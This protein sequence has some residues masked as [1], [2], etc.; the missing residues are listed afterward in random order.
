MVLE[1]VNKSYGD[2][3]IFRDFSY[4]FERGKITAVLGNS[5]VGKTTLLNI[6]AGTTS[7][8]GDIKDRGEVSFVF[9]NDRLIPNL[10]V[11]ENLKLVNNNIDVN[12]ELNK[13]GLANSRGMFPN[14]LSAGMARRVAIVRA[15]N[16]KSDVLLLDEAFRNLDYALKY[17]M[18]DLIK[19]HHKKNK[20]TIIEV[21]HDISEAVY[22]ADRIVILQ[23]GQIVHEINNI[24][25]NTEKEILK[26][27]LKQ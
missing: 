20:N 11:A 25:D 24:N 9:Q 21:T 19:T 12:E 17:K 8:D 3:V 5:G 26:F 4:T 2:R 7:F 18:M 27:F 16:Y 13:I 15:V 6:I 1:K 23:D 10:T 14:E 22:M